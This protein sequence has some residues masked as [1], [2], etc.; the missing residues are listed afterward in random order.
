MTVGSEA[1][2]SERGAPRQSGP[3]WGALY[4][5]TLV[6]GMLYAAYFVLRYGGLWTENDTTV[7][8]RS[9]AQ[10]ITAGTIFT[11]QQYA[12]GFAYPAWLSAV[13]IIT[14]ASVSTMNVVIMPFIGILLLLIAAFV[15]YVEVLNSRRL[16]VVAVLLLLA[17][18]DVL[19]SALRGN[20]EKLNMAFMLVG[21][22]A[23]IK[24]FGA[25]QRANVGDY[26]KWVLVF[27]AVM[28]ANAAT[29]DY[30][31][32]TLVIASTLTLLVAWIFTSPKR[33]S[34]LDRS[35][36][37]RMMFT[38]AVSWLLILWVMFFVFPPA[39]ADFSLLKTGFDKITALFL[40]LQPSSNPY[41]AAQDQWASPL[42]SVAL[43]TFR[44]IL[45]VGS[46][47]VWLWHMIR[48]LRGTLRPSLQELLLL[49]LYTGFGLVV[50]GS[51]ASDLTN[52]SFGTNLE[53]R[54]FTYF[55]L[56]AA[57]MLVHGA[58][59]YLTLVRQRRPQPDG[60]NPA[61]ILVTVPGAV[62]N[63]IP[64]PILRAGATL[65]VLVFIGVGLPKATLDP[66]VS[67][68]WTFYSPAESQAVRFY[69]GSNP[70]GDL[71]PLWVGPD[72]RVANALATEYPNDTFP[73]LVHGA[74]AGNRFAD[75]WLDSESV[76]I[77]SRLNDYAMPPFQ[78]EDRVYDNG[79]AQ[80]YSPRPQS[81]FQG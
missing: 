70:G 17:S 2:S 78:Q 9:A 47:A 45:F 35:V 37:R 7:F 4:L 20:H 26:A 16:G 75:D 40:S 44:Y 52:L 46:F 31:S 50:L 28:F 79:G 33:G 68:E 76:S 1:L 3:T 6:S 25:M 14:G 48:L 22:W 63:R 81:P 77:S 80:I 42:V 53:L 65:V 36:A 19:F 51:V 27:Y 5:L 15:L 38:V 10:T 41:V 12:H 61:R 73:Y 54:T 55:A 58:N 74:A 56:L 72:T 60:V 32:S 29:N 34:G 30:F 62:V 59:E 57:P 11:P 23:L 43:A 24:G 8:T 18:P 39:G 66:S 49:A 21:V 64:A 69:V 67:N 71:R 13:S